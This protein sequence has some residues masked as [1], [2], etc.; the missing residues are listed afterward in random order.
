MYQIRTIQIQDNP[1]IA[2]VIREVSKEFGLAPESGFAVADPILDDLY[3]VY[4]Q[5][6]A[7]YWIIEDA[8]G[9]VVGKRSDGPDSRLRIGMGMQFVEQTVG[10]FR[11]AVEQ[12]DI[13]VQGIPHACVDRSGK[14]KILFILD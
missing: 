6:N 1:S 4:A 8:N 10:D 14:A 5:P 11:I 12:Q 2:Q 3:Q 7:Q 9:R 13:I